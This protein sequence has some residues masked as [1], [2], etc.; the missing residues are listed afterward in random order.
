M[1]VEFYKHSL[2]DEDIQNTVKALRSLFLTTGPVCAEFENRFSSFTGVEHTVALSSC[3]AAIQLTL[4]A[5]GVGPGNEVITTPMTFIATA[6]AI[7]HTGAKPVL[8]DIEPET[9]LID[10]DLVE[11]AITPKTKAIVPVHLYGTMADMKAFR[12]IADR[13]G[14]FLVE[15]AAHC[16][17]GERDGIR[18]GQISDAAC[19]SFYAT[20]NLTC[21]EG[22]ALA[23][24][25]RTL[26]EKVR[27]LRQHGMSNEA[28]DRYHGL[29]QHWDMV[30][31]GW[32]YN[33]NDILA[34]LLITQMARLRFYWEKRQRLYSK[35]CEL[36]E[37]IDILT[38]P[39]LRGKSAHHLFT[40][41]VPSR[42]RD[43]LVRYLGEERIGVAVNYRAIH[44]LTWFKKTFGFQANDFP[45]AKAFGDRTISLPF[46]PN[47]QGEELNAVVAAVIGGLNQIPK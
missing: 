15:D 22:G 20:K 16:I 46:Y 44:T 28:S 42:L 31:L 5:L 18:P 17:E 41:H 21:G 11:S 43:F 8:V 47:L 39:E 27:T 40:I 1:K 35:Y 26:A 29:Y 38:I 33:F 19:Y 10:P 12:S 23:T 14:L 13:H 3:T 32:K 37:G 36:F 9:G 30:D 7:I 25:N 6:T 4:E 34:A 45:K 24:N 2:I